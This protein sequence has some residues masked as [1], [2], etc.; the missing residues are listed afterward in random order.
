MS[1]VRNYISTDTGAPT[2]TGTAG[3]MCTFL[4]AILSTGYNS[5]TITITQTGGVATAT[6][7]N[8]GFR[9]LQVLLVSGATPSAYNGE[10]TVLSVPTAN[11]FTF[12]V[13]AATA[14]PATGTIT[15]IVEG[16]G[17]NMPYSGTNKQVWK[18]AESGASGIPLRIDDSNAQYAALNSYITMSDVDTGSE[19]WF[20]PYWKKSSTSD[21]TARPWVAIADGKTLHL[22]IGWNQTIGSYPIYSHYVF[23]DL[24]SYVVGDV[25]QAMLCGHSASAPAGL[26]VDVGTL[27]CGNWGSSLS[28]SVGVKVARAL[29]GGAS[30][31]RYLRALSMAGALSVGNTASG[32]DT[33]SA[34]GTQPADNGVHF[35]PVSLGEYDGLS[36]FPIRGDSRGHFHI[37]ESSIAVGVNGFSLYPGPINLTG[38]TL[39]LIRTGAGTGPTDCREAIDLTGPWA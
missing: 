15:A 3:S 12:A 20:A 19:S 8:H 34:S 27:A 26:G 33:T 23:G 36:K 6:C 25:Y 37:I 1:T 5:K 13:P 11:T 28:T 7:N 32:A 14:S 17:W 9:A 18:S 29:T 30:S 2:I 22:F 10:M 31:T 16:A 4:T 24:A 38:R 39:L 21:S 35:Y